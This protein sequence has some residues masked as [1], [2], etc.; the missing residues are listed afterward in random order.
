MLAAPEGTVANIWRK[1]GD[2]W[3]LL[4]PT[5]FP[6]EARLHTL[7]E[8]APQ[9][10]PLSGSPTLVIV[11]REVAL[12]AGRAD[13][14]AVDLDGHPVIIEIKLARNAEARRAVVSQVLA[15]AAFLFGKDV[16]TL[17]REILG[18][19]LRDRQY[20]SLA[21]AAA[22][23]Y[24]EGDF[25]AAQFR[26][27]LETNLAE[28]DFRLVVVLDSAPEEL[29][30]LARYLEAISSRLT[31]DLITVSAYDVQ[32]STIL[33]PQRVDPGRPAEEGASP[34]R[35]P[36]PTTGGELVDGADDFITAIPTAAPNEQAKLKRLVSWAKRIEA[37]RLAKLETYHGVN[38]K[39]L[40]P[41]LFQGQVGL[42][43]IWNDNG[44]SL[45]LWRSVIA[46]RA[47]NSMARVE[48]ALAPV[49][50]KQGNTVREFS[51]EL[52]DALLDAYRE[53]AH[54]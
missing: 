50:L 26:A 44:A 27:N 53:A 3:A 24:Q 12:G 40:L 51:D 9:L 49:P 23:E 37:D 52:L 6:D 19:H 5:D 25:D 43:T 1:D 33:V 41:R 34:K 4:A 46:K 18:A 29:V 8:D 54:G 20:T 11:G 21:E 7:V 48:A 28:G 31:I 47:P 38:R 36:A 22:Q 35:K 39:I 14:L 45:Q 17:E 13:L 30:R 15:Y 2:G 10:L 32:G 42:A 16:D